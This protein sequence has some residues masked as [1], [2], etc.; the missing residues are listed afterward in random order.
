V[1][2]FHAPASLARCLAALG[3]QTRCPEAVLVVDNG[4]PPDATLAEL[5]ES[6]TGRA[7]LMPTGTNLGPAGGHAVGLQAFHRMAEFSHAWVMDDDCV[8]QPEGLAELV[9]H[10]ANLRSGHVVFPSWVDGRTGIATNYPGWCGFLIDQHA[11]AAAGLP[12]AD[13]F[14]WAED[15]EYLQHRMPR[16]GV[17][18]S[19]APAAVVIHEPVRRAAGRTPWKT[20][21]EARNSTYYRLHVQRRWPIGALK[22]LRALTAILLSALRETPRLE[23]LLMFGKGVVDGLFGRLGRRVEPRPTRSS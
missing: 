3:R 20:Y 6:L 22:L 4:E 2:T 12:R 7:Q 11:V 1:L 23:R 8:P 14:W 17:R 10:A 13:F 19:R 16:S 15:T 18:V 5:P 9:R 21:Y